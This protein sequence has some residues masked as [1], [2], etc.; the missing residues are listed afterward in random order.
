MMKTMNKDNNTSPYSRRMIS[1]DRETLDYILSDVVLRGVFQEWA[2]NNLCGENLSFFFSAVAFESLP[3][4]SPPSSSPSSSPLEV[5]SRRIYEQFIKEGAPCQ[6]NLDYGEVCNIQAQLSSPSP[7]MF[8]PAKSA[9]LDLIQFDILGKF[10]ASTAYSPFKGEDKQKTNKRF[11]P[12]KKA[13]LRWRDMPS[14][15]SDSITKLDKCIAD[16]VAL[17]E[18]MKFTKQERSDCDLRLFLAVLQFEE[19]PTYEE[20]INIK[21]K[22]LEEGA[23]EGGHQEVSAMA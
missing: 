21:K 5:E 4:L 18:F 14:I 13:T 6:I 20:A 12:R 16:P 9:I 2:D 17:S 7:S 3:S 11:P 19:N 8:I 15:R 22:Y 1:I 10:F 23:Q